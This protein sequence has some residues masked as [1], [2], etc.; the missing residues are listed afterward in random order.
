[1][2]DA[3]IQRLRREAVEDARRKG[4]ATQGYARRGRVQ[5][6]AVPLP[7]PARDSYRVDFYVSGVPASLRVLL[8]VELT[9]EESR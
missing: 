7:W 4:V 3:Q 2:L 5:A 8:E 6:V 1:M 9:S